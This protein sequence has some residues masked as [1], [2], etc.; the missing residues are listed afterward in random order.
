M[1]C[2]LK[3]EEGA[4]VDSGSGSSRGRGFTVSKVGKVGNAQ[5]ARWRWRR[6]SI[7]KLGEVP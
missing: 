3:P 1:F 5:A 2:N 4:R 7:R 6:C